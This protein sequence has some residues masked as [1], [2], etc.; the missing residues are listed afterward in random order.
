VNDVPVTTRTLPSGLP[1]FDLGDLD[2][3]LGRL[4]V[5]DACVG[6]GMLVAPRKRPLP[7]LAGRAADGAAKVGTA[8]DD[9]ML[10]AVLVRHSR[11][12]QLA[13]PGSA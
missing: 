13:L 3:L 9:D 6:A 12:R 7:R 2:P 1:Q 5:N 8:T 4:V 11:H 10:E